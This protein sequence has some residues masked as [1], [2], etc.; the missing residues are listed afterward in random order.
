MKKT[1]N[2]LVL[3]FFISINALISCSL[4]PLTGFLKIDVVED[5]NSFANML[6]KQKAV[7]S[8]DKNKFEDH[9][10]ITKSRVQ[11]ATN[12]SGA[13]KEKT[14][15][16]V[17]LEREFFQQKLLIVN[18]SY[19]V[20]T[21]IEQVLQRIITLVESHIKLLQEYK[22]DPE[23]K[24]KNL[25]VPIKSLYLFS[26][27]Q[28]I[29]DRMVQYDTELKELE[30]K[31]KK[32]T[33]DVSNRQKIQSIARQEYAEKKKQQAEFSVQASRSTD[34]VLAGDSFT[35]Q[36][37]GELLDEEEKLF[38]YKRELADAYLRESEEKRNILVDFQIKTTRLQLQILKDEYE[39]V[40]R[41]FQVDEQYKT[42]VENELERERQESTARQKKYKES[43]EG[44][45]VVTKYSL[46]EELIT[47]KQQFSLSDSDINNIAQ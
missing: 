1:Y 30:E 31:A 3:L 18:Q 24:S 23:F 28:K 6:E 22:Q 25:K 21:E 35:I 39:R 26:D 15:S 36:Q 33:D 19:Q 45:D 7:L 13:L 44:L 11:A 20:L 37:R 46:N 9:L 27:L 40:K 4:G 42:H 8:E 14:K 10:R 17:G 12:E 29:N 47:Y 41:L 2:Y 43:I 16:A 5:S 34:D 38:G 32:I